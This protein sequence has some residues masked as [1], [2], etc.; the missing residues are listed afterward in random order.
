MEQ[1]HVLCVVSSMQK[2]YVVMV[3]ICVSKRSINCKGVVS[4][5]TVITTRAKD[6]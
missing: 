3:S 6:V 2:L 1:L 5:V 4:S